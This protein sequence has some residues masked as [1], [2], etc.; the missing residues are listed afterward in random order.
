M[1]SS[2]PSSGKP[3]NK[4]GKGAAFVEIR[5]RVR[6]IVIENGWALVK[7]EGVPDAPAGPARRPFQ[8]G[9]ARARPAADGSS[10]RPFVPRTGP[11][12]AKFTK[13]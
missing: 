7:L 8:A 9:A 4:N 5:Q 13:Y 10:G 12:E 6:E 1:P 11:D 3:R 2:S